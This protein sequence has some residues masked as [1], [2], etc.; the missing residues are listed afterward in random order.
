VWP[1]FSVSYNVAASVLG[2]Q[3]AYEGENAAFDFLSLTNFTY[4]D[5]LQFHS[6]TC[7]GQNFIL[8]C[9]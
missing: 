5:V 8:L 2:L 1:P 3:S 7:K 9:D 4:D 6:F